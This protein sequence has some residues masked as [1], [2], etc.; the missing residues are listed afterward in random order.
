VNKLKLMKKIALSLII[1]F[2]VSS[3]VFS[4]AK[5]V[6]K[7][8]KKGNDIVI[9]FEK[10]ILPNG[11]TVIISEDHSDPIV[12]VDVTYHVG[13][14]REEIGKSGF[15]HFFEHMM[16]E[17][18][19]HVADKQHFKIVTESGGTLNGST[20]TDRTNYYETV[21]SNQ[22]EKMLWLES[23]R[24]GFLMNAVTQQKFEIQRSTVKN[25]RGQNYDNR[26]YGLA[27]EV[28]AKA[29]YPYGHPYSWL[30]IGY[31]EDLNRV[32]VND[33]KNF[34]LRWYGPNNATLT[35]G[36]D[37]NTKDVINKVE[38]YFGS[39]PRGPE[40]KPVQL[41][42]VKLTKKEYVS[43]VDNYAKLPLLAIT[44]PTVPDYNSDMAPLACL[45]QVLGQGRTSALYQNLVKPQ[46][47]LQANAYSSLD[48]LA[49]TFNI[50]VIPLPGSN[51][52][53]ME[54]LVNESLEDFEKKG[55]TDNDI[56]KF[57]NGFESNT[58]NRLASV[59]GK[60]AQL[61]AFETFTGDPNMIGKLLDMYKKVTKE[62]VMRV[63]NKYIKNKPSVVLSVLPKGKENLIAA[64]DNF[65]VDSSHYVRPH[66]GYE[67]LKYNKPEDNFDRNKIPPSG[68]NPVV[69]VPDFWK[70]TLTDGITAIG[71]ESNEIPVVNLNIYLKGGNILEQD[72]LSKAGLVNLFTSM[73]TEDTKD[74]SSEDINLAL[75]KLGS[76]I[77]V[78]NST[79]AIIFSVQSLSKNLSKTLSILQERMLRPKFTEETFNRIKRQ[80]IESIKNAKSQASSVANI[81]FDKINY[82]NNV[83]GV[84]E[85]GTEETVKNIS[86]NDIQN[87]Y[88]HFISSE[89][90]QVVVV[91]SVK[92][93]DILPQLNFLN[94]LPNKSITITSV[95]A[96]PA[97]EKAKIYVVNIPHAA[98]TEFRVG[99]V[100]DMKYDATGNY[101][102]AGLTNYNLGGGFNSRLN[103]KLREDKG[104]TYGARSG[105][106][107]NKY[108][109]TFY[110]SSGIRANATDSALAAFLTDLKNYNQH[111]PDNDEV[112][113]MKNSIGQSDARNYET[114]SQKASFLSRILI[115][116][117]PAN[118]VDQQTKILN[119][120]ST[121]EI[122]S[123]AKKYFDIDKMNI[124]LVGDKDLFM[125]AL[126]QFGYDIVELDANGNQL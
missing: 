124:L 2:S 9:P 115:Y 30:T 74:R 46:K 36:G 29:L 106:T 44:Y 17:G 58:I 53:D 54:K 15:A 11:L 123:L 107:G 122:D 31:V 88:D 118:F 24:M 8:V 55:V 110:F 71:V 49:G 56:E 90:A 57:K 103:I 64:A 47:A 38:K 96:A 7:V 1:L 65:T 25:E 116:N 26:P 99:Y 21:P 76:S 61:A 72:D 16:F 27:R 33:L 101:Y 121:A 20:N 79:D 94:Q 51:L 92:E 68:P 97:V 18:S 50:N 73:M 75:E 28:T 34:F 111:G 82:G 126:K 13:S 84:A 102:K 4:Q 40:V 41:P 117:L 67:G 52:S 112:T 120:I 60:A 95:P 89:G 5:L 66:Y 83:F 86:L 81:V 6:E 77:N 42:P 3:I 85:R 62:D 59:A 119:N 32:N 104:W 39:I 87:Y 43:Y 98:Q 93:N 35:I 100:T 63:Y 91:G 37:V 14:A 10:Y 48:E 125:P 19:D 45:A 69:K 70:K 23:D 80:T 78:Y 12:H 22:L 109:G 114:G 105:F 113:F 108:T